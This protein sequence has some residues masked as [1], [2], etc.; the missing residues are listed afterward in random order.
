MQQ[1]LKILAPTGYFYAERTI[2]FCLPI[3]LVG[4][5]HR[6]NTYIK[7]WFLSTPISNNHN[8]YQLLENQPI[9]SANSKLCGLFCIYIAHFVFNAQKLVNISDNE[10]IRFAFHMII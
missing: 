8:I 10:L 6:T 4:P 1:L 7:E 3:P 2:N 9:Q 5:F